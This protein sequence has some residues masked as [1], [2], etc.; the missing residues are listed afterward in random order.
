MNRKNI[1][2]FRGIVIFTGLLL[3]MMIFPGYA[4]AFDHFVNDPV[5]TDAG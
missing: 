3:A 1:S 5:K 4:T 2:G